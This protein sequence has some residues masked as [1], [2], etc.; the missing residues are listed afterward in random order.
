MNYLPKHRYMCACA[1]GLDH[2]MSVI[3]TVFT[4]SAVGLAVVN[5]LLYRRQQ[6]SALERVATVP[7]RTGW[8]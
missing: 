8:R 1:A 5:V 4:R 6:S 7:Y 2:R 3:P